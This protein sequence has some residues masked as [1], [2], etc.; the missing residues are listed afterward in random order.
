LVTQLIALEYAD[1]STN[2]N[3]KTT[4]KANTKKLPVP[5]PKKPS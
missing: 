4:T 2:S 3:P 1:A 5:G